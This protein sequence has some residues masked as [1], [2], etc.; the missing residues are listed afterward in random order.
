MNNW[1]LGA[2]KEFQWGGFAV[3]ILIGT[4]IGIFLTL[5]YIEKFK[6]GLENEA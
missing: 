1:M 6:G 3:G 5:E 4:L 2:I